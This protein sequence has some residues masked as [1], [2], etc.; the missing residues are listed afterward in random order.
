MFRL[1][2]HRDVTRIRFG[3]SGQSELQ[4]RA[5]RGALHVGFRTD[6]LLYV[7]DHAVGF[8]QRAARRHDVVDDEATF[9][10]RWQ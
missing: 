6:D 4:A 1:E 3:D 5:S 10:H 2:P 9:V 7:A 8:S